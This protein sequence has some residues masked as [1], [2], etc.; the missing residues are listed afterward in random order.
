MEEKNVF[1]ET[2][3][4]VLWSS[5]ISTKEK[6]HLFKLKSSKRPFTE[7]ILSTRALRMHYFLSHLQNNGDRERC[8]EKRTQGVFC[9]TVLRIVTVS[10]SLKWGITQ[11]AHFCALS[12]S[13]YLSLRAQTCRHTKTISARLLLTS[14][15]TLVL[16]C[17][18]SDWVPY[19]LDQKVRK[20]K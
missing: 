7:R 19:M 1:N 10:R 16:F 12:L 3:V 13:L 9:C 4:G 6:K 15:E 8:F 17:W 2:K 20:M 5:Q 14:T 18:T 11:E